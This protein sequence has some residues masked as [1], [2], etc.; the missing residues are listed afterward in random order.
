MGIGPVL[1][2]EET[3]F[4]KEVHINEVI[5][6]TLEVQK[7]RKDGTKWTIIHNI[8]KESGELACRII[9][10]GSWLDLERRKVAVPPNQL[11]EMLSNAPRTEDFR[12]LP[13]KPAN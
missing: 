5:T 13:D 1:F 2:R 10:D 9:A 12:W 6:V 3:K 8:Y 7:I 4:I 11:A